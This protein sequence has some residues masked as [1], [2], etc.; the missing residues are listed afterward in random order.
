MKFLLSTTLAAL[1]A[2]SYATCIRQQPVFEIWEELAPGNLL[3]DGDGGGSEFIVGTNNLIHVTLGTN[4]P[5]RVEGLPPELIPS[6]MRLEIV[7][8]RWGAINKGASYIVA[9]GRKY[10]FGGNVEERRAFKK[11]FNVFQALVWAQEN[12][13]CPVDSKGQ[14]FPQLSSVRI[15]LQTLAAAFGIDYCLEAQFRRAGL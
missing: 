8:K 9:D 2:W 13:N 1:C 6:H 5:D 11:Q 3:C 4:S 10:R 7:R 12:G 15:S 14:V